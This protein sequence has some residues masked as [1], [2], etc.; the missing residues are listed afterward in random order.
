MWV[1]CITMKNKTKESILSYLN[2]N[3]SSHILKDLNKQKPMYE[4]R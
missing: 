4:E 1:Y 3:G 2:R